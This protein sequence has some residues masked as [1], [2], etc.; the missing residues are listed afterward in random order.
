ML[1][2][3]IHCFLL[4]IVM[5]MVLSDLEQCKEVSFFPLSDILSVQWTPVHCRRVLLRHTVFIRSSLSNVKNWKWLLVFQS[6]NC[7]LQKQ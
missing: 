6:R 5:S 3:P 1:L 7:P 2:L 4:F